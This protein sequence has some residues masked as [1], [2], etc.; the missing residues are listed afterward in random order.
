ML[1]PGRDT[2]LHSGTHSSCGHL[3]RIKPFKIPVGKGK[4]HWVLAEGLLVINTY[5]GKD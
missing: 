2:L 4:A 1:S 5:W 3:H